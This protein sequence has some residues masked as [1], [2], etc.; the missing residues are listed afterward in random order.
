LELNVHPT[1]NF[2]WIFHVTWNFAAWRA[3]GTGQTAAFGQERSLAAVAWSAP[4]ESHIALEL[5]WS[6]STALESCLAR[7]STKSIYSNG[8]SRF[9]AF[10]DGSKTPS[11]SAQS[12]SRKQVFVT[13]WHFSL[14]MG[15]QCGSSPNSK[16]K[17]TKSGSQRR[18]CTGTR[19]FS[20]PEARSA[21]IAVAGQQLTFDC[22]FL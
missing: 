8:Q 1:W 5:E 17:K 3:A 18:T 7:S 4:G 13:F 10:F 19:R 15:Y 21:K 20:A 16:V 6:Y 22:W 9:Q 11:W 12:E 14:G 2:R